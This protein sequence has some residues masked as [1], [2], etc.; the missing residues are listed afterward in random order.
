MRAI[1]S[2]IV[3]FLAAILLAITNP[4]ADDFAVYMKT[5][6]EQETKQSGASDPLSAM[7]KTFAA[8]MA[9]EAAGQT[10]QRDDYGLFSL[11][12]VTVDKTTERWV[13]VL[14]QFIRLP[15]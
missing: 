15:R 9:A 8:W 5:A 11:Y 14:K 6:Y 2:L 1:G 3:V 10:V 13:G 4:T 7:M 12:S